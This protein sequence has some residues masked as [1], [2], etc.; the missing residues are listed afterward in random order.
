MDIVSEFD[1]SRFKLGA[2][3]KH[4][5]EWDK[6]G[7]SL[8]TKHGNCLE[9]SRVNGREFHRKRG[10]KARPDDRPQYARLQKILIETVFDDNCFGWTGTV[11][12]NGYGFIK[13]N[14][15]YVRTHRV[16]LEYK[17]GRP[18]KQNM[19][20]CHKCDNPKCIN[21]NHLFEGSHQDNMRDMRN[22]GRECSPQGERSGMAKLNES[23]VL[24]IRKLHAQGLSRIMIS[25]TMKV[26]I[27]TIDK[28]I[29]RDTWKH[30]P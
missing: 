14:K 28:I 3:C 23:Q 29:Y 12:V 15:K 5:H 25:T 9:C 10:A 22:K 8:R 24:E 19:F 4:N 20:A 13:H 16:A 2:F 27:S 18:I 17:L 30:L 1:R 26:P 21:P 11:D 7:K 6:T